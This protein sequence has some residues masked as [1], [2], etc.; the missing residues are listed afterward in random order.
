[1]DQKGGDKQKFGLPLQVD[2]VFFLQIIQIFSG[3][4]GDRDVMNVDL[5]FAYE[6][7]EQIQRS[8]KSLQVDLV[9]KLIMRF[10]GIFNTLLVADGRAP[11][12][13][14]NTRYRE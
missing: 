3:N 14:L 13:E 12:T 10:Y 4:N 2:F 11:P 8:L 1:M 7:Q 9:F 6:K 5:F